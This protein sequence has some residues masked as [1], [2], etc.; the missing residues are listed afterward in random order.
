MREDL[1]QTHRAP[2][3]WSQF[4]P[5]ILLTIFA[6]FSIKIRKWTYASIILSV[7]DRLTCATISAWAWHARCLRENNKK[8][9]Q[10]CLAK[11]PKWTCCFTLIQ[12]F[13]IR[14]LHCLFSIA[15][16]NYTPFIHKQ[17]VCVWI[18]LCM[19]LS[20]IWL[21]GFNQVPRWMY[22]FTLIKNPPLTFS[23]CMLF[24]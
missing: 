18:C 21:T 17:P 15:G 24:L 22:C 8:Y 4:Q 1:W 16:N 5:F 20:D 19:S 7:I 10:R 23:D 6:V 14:F 2:A 9:K 3:E 11:S 12:L 13:S